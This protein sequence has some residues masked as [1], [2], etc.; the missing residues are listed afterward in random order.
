MLTLWHG[1]TFRIISTLW[2]NPPTRC[3]ELDKL[4]NKLTSYW[5]FE[6]PW[7]SCDVN[8]DVTKKF[9]WRR[10]NGFPLS[11]V[12]RMIRDAAALMWH[13]CNRAMPFLNERIIRL[14]LLK[15]ITGLRD[16]YKRVVK[17]EE[18]IILLLIILNVFWLA[19]TSCFAY[20]ACSTFW[21]LLLNE[22]WYVI[23]T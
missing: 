22:S 13:H 17:N 3:C 21:K 6:T 9:F 18:K 10:L 16:S 8:T 5:G 15:Q 7:C 1:N 11:L 23:V 19:V 20:V 2:G 4:W 12:F 14:W